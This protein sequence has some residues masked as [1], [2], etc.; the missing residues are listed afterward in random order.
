MWDDQICKLE[1][2]RTDYTQ[3]E[4]EKETEIKQKKTKTKQKKNFKDL[5]GN[6]R[7]SNICH[8]KVSEEKETMAER[9]FKEIIT[10]NFSNVAKDMSLQIQ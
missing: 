9:G 6:N 3:S 2:I 1:K 7:R 10:E 4:Q 8:I 5:C